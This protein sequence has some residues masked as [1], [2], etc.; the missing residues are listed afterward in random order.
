MLGLHAT[1]SP[2][3]SRSRRSLDVADTPTRAPPS[4][5]P[6]APR[7]R[8]T[9]SRQRRLG[10]KR[11]RYRRPKGSPVTPL[12]QI[13]PLVAKKIGPR[14]EGSPLCDWLETILQSGPPVDPALEKTLHQAINIHSIIRFDPNGASVEQKQQLNELCVKLKKAIKALPTGSTKSA[15]LANP[16]RS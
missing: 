4:A 1:I 11:R 2:G 7:W 10:V 5:R 12:H 8:A 14:P 16:N 9:C 13:E 15:K 3:E 6:H